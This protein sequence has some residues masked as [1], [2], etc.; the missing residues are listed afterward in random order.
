[1]PIDSD[2]HSGDQSEPNDWD[3]TVRQ[4]AKLDD[5]LARFLDQS[6]D[7]ETESPRAELTAEIQRIAW[8][9]HSEEQREFDADASLKQVGHYQ[10]LGPLGSGGMGDVYVARHIVLDRK[11]ALKLLK[12]ERSVMP[13]PLERFHREM[14]AL[15]ALHHPH[16]VCAYDGDVYDGMVYLA[17]ELVEGINLK[18]LYRQQSDLSLEVV[19]DLIRQ[20]ALGLGAL[21]DAGIV[22][23]DIKPS[24]LMLTRQGIVKILDLGLA[25]LVDEGSDLTGPLYA[26][27]TE[28]FMS[29]EQILGLPDID[30][31]SDIYSLGR[32]LQRLLR[33]DVSEESGS[34]SS[35]RRA[36][37]R[38][39]AALIREMM[40]ENREQR[41]SSAA[42]VA[43]RLAGLSGRVDSG[44]I[45]AVAFG[46]SSTGQ[47][48]ETAGSRSGSKVT[49]FGERPAYLHRSLPALGLMAA[50][51]TAV[52]LY[53]SD[54]L[55]FRKPS[56]GPEVS[57]ESSSVKPASEAASVGDRS[58][59]GGDSIPESGTSEISADMFV[60]ERMV[61]LWVLENG[62]TVTV[63][64]RTVD[65][66][67]GR[68]VKSA[69]RVPQQ[70][71]LIQV[72]DLPSGVLTEAEHQRLG[73]LYGLQ[74][75]HLYDKSVSDEL[76]FS[77]NP[78][79][80]LKWL[81]LTGL[82]VT[83]RGVAALDVYR[84]TLLTL[85]I[86]HTRVTD[87]S[88]RLLRVFP[89]LRGLFMGNTA[90]TDAAVPFFAE[91]P[92]LVSLDISYTQVTGSGI[93][94]LAD[95]KALTKLKCR[96]LPLIDEDLT[97]LASIEL[98]E[99]DVRETKISATAIQE[100]RAAH[101]DCRVEY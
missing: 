55:P 67:T 33:W 26:V 45:T 30:H 16:V 37:Y 94:A 62:G 15:A 88:V 83:D 39:L 99:L 81:Y 24:N 53:S 90:V 64:F 84:E 100:Y 42:T 2:N 48:A 50:V 51:A 12:P 61:A 40:A 98:V 29:P 20:A 70:P 82:D 91:Y 35:S 73:S 63:N 31:R 72:L 75:L 71:F 28:R 13:G 68:Q 66:W 6:A 34:G 96:H 17:M 36:N 56:S 60:N 14:R 41:L 85:N 23:R 46:I 79:W 87:E 11:V 1:M 54:L 4:N 44:T 7:A 5:L 8:Q 97:Q 58:S 22:H 92:S 32:T 93:G 25:R 43:E 101:P 76:I 47:P 78:R 27:G 95:C 18:Q 65:G 49:T 9:Q 10:I 89:S 80:Q 59:D 21:H 69:D 19:C 77:L 74:G 86:S 52:G 38:P 3:A 57:T